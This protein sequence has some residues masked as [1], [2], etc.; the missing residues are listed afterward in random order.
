[1]CHALKL[2]IPTV[3][4]LLGAIFPIAVIAFVWGIFLDATLPEDYSL[5]A[6]GPTWIIRSLPVLLFVLPAYVIYLVYAHPMIDRR[7]R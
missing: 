4:A 1:M 3:R 5:L 2:A 6:T 7:N